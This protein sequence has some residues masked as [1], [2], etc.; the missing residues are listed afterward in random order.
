MLGLRLYY[1][2]PLSPNTSPCRLPNIPSPGFIGDRPSLETVVVPQSTDDLPRDHLAHINTYQ[3]HDEHA[4]P[5][6][7]VLGKL[8]E[9]TGL[10]LRRVERLQL[11]PEV[12][13]VSGPVEGAEE[14][15]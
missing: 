15:A 1:F 3:T 10:P 14:P 7:V 13:Y 9:Y 8:G 5:P 6:Q 2:Q 4:I 12:L 11:L